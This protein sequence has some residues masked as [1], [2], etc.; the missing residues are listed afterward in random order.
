MLQIAKPSAPRINNA[1]QMYHSRK[2]SGSQDSL[3]NNAIGNKVAVGKTQRT[4]EPRFS[5]RGVLLRSSKHVTSQR[6]TATIR[7][8]VAL[9]FTSMSLSAGPILKKNAG[10]FQAATPRPTT[11]ITI[12][13]LDANC[14]HHNCNTRYRPS[15]T[16]TTC[17][18]T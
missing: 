16:P 9:C 4:A 13:T 5:R 14:Q 10:Q 2:Y 6:T 8:A 3:A 12:A 18:V 1:S 7:K 11:N 17:P 15:V